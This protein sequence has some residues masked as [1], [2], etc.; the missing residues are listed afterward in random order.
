MKEFTLSGPG[1]F[2]RQ[3]DPVIWARDGAV[4]YYNPA[5]AALAG[6]WGWTLAEGAA[7]PPPL[8]E[9]AAGETGG[10]A[11]NG[12]AWTCRTWE[13]EG[14]TLFQLSP[15]LESGGLTLDRLSQ[16]AGQLRIPLGNLIG[17]SQLLEYPRADRAPEKTEQYRSI[18]RKNYYILLRMLDSL[19]LLGDL[20]AGKT[21]FRPQVLDLGGLCAD[22]VRRAQGVGAQAGC[23]LTLDQRDGNL[24]VD[25][26]EWMLRKLIYQLLSNAIRA[27]GD[28]G[29]VVLRLEIREKQWVRITVSDSGAG[30]SAAQLARAFDPAQSGDPLAER[31]RGLGLGISICRLVAEQH[32]GRMA[33]LSGGGGTAVVELP[34]SSGVEA[35]ELR[36]AQDYC[37]G[38]NET[39]LQ[40]A[41]VLPWQCFQSDEG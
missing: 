1:W 38:L 22:V 30:F 40:L 34:R 14:G 15:A 6:Q 26:E 5:A 31:D 37:G 9:L 24:L 16:I 35:G 17:A 39:L 3:P 19:E 18:Q 13:L 4:A 20:S 23:A 8:A 11:L 2:D 7:L 25:G 21:P 10:F 27:A 36:S 33:L 29:K 12:T 32:G 41:D 28:G